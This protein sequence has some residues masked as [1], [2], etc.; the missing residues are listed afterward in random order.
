MKKKSSR[1]NPEP[2][3]AWHLDFRNLETLPDVKV[4]RTSFFIHVGAVLFLMAALVFLGMQEWHRRSLRFEIGGLEEKIAANQNRNKEVLRLHGEF[5]KEE[6]TISAV[7]DHVESS[8]ELSNLLLAFASALPAEM[9]FNAIRY[10]ERKGGDPGGQE[11]TI[12][13]EILATPD[14]AATILTGYVSSFQEIPF[15]GE[16]VAEAVPT[17]LVASPEGKE[18]SFGIQVTLQNIEDSKEEKK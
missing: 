15:L 11:L 7:L 3:P 1:R 12:Q 2:M 6:K 17:S 14:D 16:R 4:E 10:R 18:L 8:P 13:G 5:Q 9:R